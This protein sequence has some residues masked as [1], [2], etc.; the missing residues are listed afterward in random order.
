MIP[1]RAHAG[2]HPV[3]NTTLFCLTPCHRPDYK[4]LGIFKQRFPSVPMLALTATATPRVQEDVK[5]QLKIPNCLVFKS[6]FN[7]PNLRCGLHPW[8]CE[9]V[10]ASLGPHTGGPCADCPRG[11]PTILG[12]MITFY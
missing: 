6:S 3:S 10:W 8:Q 7:R 4:T 11:L 1:Q 9:A 12:T 5:L 2:A